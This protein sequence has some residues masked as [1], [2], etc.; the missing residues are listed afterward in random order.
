MSI[1]LSED[2]LHRPGS[3]FDRAVD[4]VRETVA[5]G[6]AIAIAGA[7]ASVYAHFL[8]RIVSLSR[9]FDEARQVEHQ[10]SR[11]F[12][13]AAR[14]AMRD[15]QDLLDL[16]D[17]AVRGLCDS[18]GIRRRIWLEASA[19]AHG[20]DHDPP[21]D[22]LA[23]L[24]LNYLLFQT[25]YEKSRLYGLPMVPFETLHDLMLKAQREKADKKKTEDHDQRILAN[26]L[27]HLNSET[28]ELSESHFQE[29]VED[30]KKLHRVL[31]KAK[32]PVGAFEET[33][34]EQLAF[35]FLRLARVYKE[36]A[37]VAPLIFERVAK[38]L[39]EGNSLAG[40]QRIEIDRQNEVVVLHKNI[41]PELLLRYGSTMNK[42]IDRI[43]NQLD[44]AQLLRKSFARAS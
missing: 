12:M 19:K 9:R 43:L 4:A 42:Q 2:K 3:D 39:S 34:V 5:D 29:S 6:D 37:R 15:E 32:R 14:L 33:L 24:R 13:R 23:K 31:R 11:E 36:D 18:L 38:T 26:I 25:F 27:R 35:E 28:E 40:T 1:S 41:D 20:S 44:R 21:S 30:Y 22:E 8:D 17:Q 7:A 16:A 10:G